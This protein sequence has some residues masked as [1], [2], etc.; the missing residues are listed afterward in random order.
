MMNNDAPMAWLHRPAASLPAHEATVPFSH[1]RRG[2]AVP[3]STAMVPHQTLR[4]VTSRDG[5]RIAVAAVGDGPP[6]LRV[7][8]WLSH[9]EHDLDSP[10]WRP[11]VQALSRQRRY[12][13]YDQRGCGL[14]DRGVA[15]LSL[16]AWV[17][18]LEAVVEGLGLARVPLFGMSQGGA[19]AVAYAA[20]HP[21]RVSQLILAG[22]Y[23]RGSLRR[24]GDARS[25]LEA[26]TLVNLIRV[27]WGGDDPTFRRVF[28]HR[29]L[30]EGS[31]EQHRWWAD[32]E[33][34][35]ASADDA[36]RT[37]AAFQDVDVTALA[38]RLQV[39]TLVLH[40]RG[41]AA[42]PFGEGRLL[43]TLIHG[44]R[45]VP[46]E[47][48]NHVLLDGE[49]AFA[50]FVAEV[51]AFLGASRDV[52]D[53]AEAALTPAER[54]V[55]ELLALGLDNAEIAAR[56]VKSE[57][58]VRNQVSSIFDKLGVRTRAQAIVKARAGR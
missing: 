34:L 40:A 52:P 2:T 4:F 12:I 44:A 32:L 51:D 49:P 7:A 38:S 5:V 16:D 33:R 21:E 26:E 35:T 50:R 43:A 24:E 58:T 47:S 53:A 20:R 11:W 22:A 1:R 10:V 14:S 42:V 45:F 57:K 13:R 23:A 17:A 55:L 48:R 25:Q 56:L 30:P 36:A 39:P 54:D 9:V 19:V 41:D 29:F 37:L 46:L 27:G 8:H 6:L 28:A 31:S 18:D 15:D 3:Q